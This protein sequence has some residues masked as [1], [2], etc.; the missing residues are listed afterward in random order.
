[1]KVEQ[2]TING[3]FIMQINSKNEWIRKFPG[4]L[5]ELPMVEK[6]IWID[7]NG[8]ITTVGEDFSYAEYQNSYPIKI[9]LIQRTAHIGNK[10]YLDKLLALFK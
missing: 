2:I 10:T 1:M 4:A 5:P 6:Y 3:T 7:A 8:N 9:Y